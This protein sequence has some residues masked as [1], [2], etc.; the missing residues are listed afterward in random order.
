MFSYSNFRPVADQHIFN[1]Y[2]QTF[3]EQSSFDYIIENQREFC[4]FLYGDSSL[5]SL[6]IFN[7]VIYPLI[8]QKVKYVTL[9]DENALNSDIISSISEYYQID[10]EARNIALYKNKK[11]SYYLHF[12]FA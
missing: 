4:F 9:L 2:I 3:F 5:E 10:V 1:S 12:V 6:S 11:W 8:S 7:E